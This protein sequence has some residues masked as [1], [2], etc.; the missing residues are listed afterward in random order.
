[1]P[2]DFGNASV[3]ML[4]NSEVDERVRALEESE[5][6]LRQQI[7]RWSRSGVFVLPDSSF[8]IEHPAKLEDVDLSPSLG[9]TTCQSMS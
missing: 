2:G 9:S 8:Y 1:M 5:T 7:E 3:V 6:A 4:L